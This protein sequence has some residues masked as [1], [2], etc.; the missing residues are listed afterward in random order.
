[1]VT[2]RNWM[3]DYMVGSVGHICMASL[4]ILGLPPISLINLLPT[5]N[6]SNWGSSVLFA[7]LFF[8]LGSRNWEC[9]QLLSHRPAISSC[10]SSVLIFNSGQVHEPSGCYSA[11]SLLGTK[12]ELQC[13]LLERFSCFSKEK[14]LL[15]STWTDA[16]CVCDT[17][18][19]P[20][21]LEAIPHSGT[22]YH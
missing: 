19:K 9:E 21:N 6:V 20:W 8:N 17:A 2:V 13:R 4:L 1:M 22:P 7:C 16:P 14:C 3:L 15:H 18:L 11:V 10:V 12:H 5:L